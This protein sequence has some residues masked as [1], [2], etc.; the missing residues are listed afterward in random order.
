MGGITPRES[1]GGAF[2]YYLAYMGV[3]TL[4]NSLGPWNDNWGTIPAMYQTGWTSEYSA[5]GVLQLGLPPAF[6]SILFNWDFVPM[7][8]YAASGLDVITATYSPDEVVAGYSYAFVVYLNGVLFSLSMSLLF[9][10]TQ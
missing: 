6:A 5:T 7:P 10:A 9:I 2:P 3:G 8:T 1:A 4:S